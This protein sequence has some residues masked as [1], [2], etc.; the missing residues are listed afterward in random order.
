MRKLITAIILFGCVW[1]MNAQHTKKVL[2]QHE[3]TLGLHSGINYYMGEG[4]AGYINPI[5]F[6]PTGYMGKVSV[7]Y[8]FTPVWGVRGFF[9]FTN[10]NWPENNVTTNISSEN[11]S[12]DLTYNV[13][14]AFSNYDPGRAIDLILFAGSGVSFRDIK[15]TKNTNIFL[16]S[17][18]GMQLDFQLTNLLDLNIIGEID[19]VGDSYNGNP[20]K[21]L[22]GTPIDLVPTLS[23]GVSYHIPTRKKSLCK[24]RAY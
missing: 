16:L 4:V 12:L 13:R 7:A 18:G 23:V 22:D 3:L 5:S 20:A 11:L 8:R 6:K 10:L 14:N 15:N 19:V 21:G 24:S 9:G 17:R 2:F 1:A